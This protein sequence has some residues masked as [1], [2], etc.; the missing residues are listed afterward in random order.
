MDNVI[1]FPAEE[2]RNLAKVE[3]EI[4]AGLREAGVSKNAEDVITPELL[5]LTKKYDSMLVREYQYKLPDTLNEDEIEGCR[6]VVQKVAQET[7][8]NFRKIMDEVAGDLVSLRLQL[9]EAKGE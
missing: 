4:R 5:E 9:Y 3:K 1:K 7:F 6:Q 2:I 8:E